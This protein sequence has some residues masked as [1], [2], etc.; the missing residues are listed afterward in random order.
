[1]ASLKDELEFTKAYLHILKERFEEGFQ[2][3]IDIP[4]DYLSRKTPPVAMQMLIENAVKH[5]VLS[6]EFPLYLKIFVE[7]DYLVVSNTI[8]HKDT[9][10]T[11]TG[12][13][14]HNIAERYRLMSEN[15]VIISDDS[16][17]FTV[18]LPLI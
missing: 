7:N 15:D 16:K 5:N 8:Q 17:T 11:S 9:M 6:E 2:I 4:S 10:E 1:M 18:K 3:N 14:L 12:I 13:G